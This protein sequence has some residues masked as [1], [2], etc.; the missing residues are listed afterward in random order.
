MC[1]NIEKL[2]DKDKTE[3]VS[4]IRVSKDFKNPE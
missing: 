4:A 1:Y 3:Y 2:R